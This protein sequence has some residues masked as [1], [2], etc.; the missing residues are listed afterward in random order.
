MVRPSFI[1]R[2]LKRRRETLLGLGFDSARPAGRAREAEV[3]GPATALG[4]T[5]VSLEG[6]SSK[7]ACLGARSLAA[8]GLRDLS[9][10]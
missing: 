5:G 2:A 10:A 1:S 8:G 3:E 7:P 4:L 9:A 6:D